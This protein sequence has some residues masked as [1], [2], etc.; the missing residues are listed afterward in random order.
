MLRHTQRKKL[1][2]DTQ[3]TYTALDI[4]V[5]REGI[6]RYPRHLRKIRRGKSLGWGQYLVST[7][8]TS[9]L[10]AAIPRHSLR[11]HPFLLALWGRF[12]RNVPSYGER[13][14]TDV[15]AG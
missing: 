13:G 15:F 7:D 2:R 4:F 3:I 8:I 1:T 12:P 9:C 5:Y 10:G 11:K 14:E 6:H